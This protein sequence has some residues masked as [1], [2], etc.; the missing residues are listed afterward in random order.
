MK[1][2]MFLCI[3]SKQYKNQNSNI[4]DSNVLDTLEDALLFGTT[5]INNDC[6][7]ISDDELVNKYDYINFINNLKESDI[8]YKIR[9]HIISTNRKRFNTSKELMDYFNTNIKN[10]SN[11]NLYDFLLSLVDSEVVLYDYNMNILYKYIE[12]TSPIKEDV[13]YSKVD[14]NEE[15]CKKGIYTFE[16][17]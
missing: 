7:E 9:I 8:D 5:T 15:D 13:Y 12:D 10:I 6:Y 1:N 14:F 16:Y 17:R 4:L 2:K 11:D 3:V